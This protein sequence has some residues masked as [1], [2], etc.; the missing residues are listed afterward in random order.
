MDD[1]IKEQRT[2]K[3]NLGLSSGQRVCEMGHGFTFEEMGRH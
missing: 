2:R 1:W 3:L